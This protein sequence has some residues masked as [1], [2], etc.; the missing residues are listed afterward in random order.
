MC[1]HIET[2]SISILY[3]DA[4]ENLHLQKTNIFCV[5]METCFPH[6]HA[7][8]ATQILT[9]VPHPFFILRLCSLLPLCSR[10]PTTSLT[11]YPK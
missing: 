6:F 8:K 1:F 2:L 4:K 3:T 10:L 7:G 11:H 9:I 5:T